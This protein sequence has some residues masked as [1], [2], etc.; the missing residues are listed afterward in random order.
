V[1]LFT[2]EEANAALDVVRPRA[3][4]LVRLRVAFRAV[5]RELAEVRT[6]A[7]GN[8]DGDTARRAAALEEARAEAVR[9]VEDVAAELD[10]LGVQVK[11]ADTGLLDFP[12]RHPD[13]SLV[14]L[15]WRLGEEAVTSWHTLDGGFAGRKP[16]PF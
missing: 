1:K 15:C 5:E 13:G 8:G 16:L 12:A 2:P 11:D 4:R 9:A 14:L 10:E 6:R 3:E 7:R